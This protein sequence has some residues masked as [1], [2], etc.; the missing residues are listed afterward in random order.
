MLN[1]IVLMKFKPEVTDGEIAEL[2]EALD[3]LP[4]YITEIHS[5]EFG[6]DIVRSDRSYDFALVAMFAN[7]ETLQRYQEHPRHLKVLEKIRAISPD[8]RVLLASGYSDREQHNRL[9]TYDGV[10]FVGKPFVADEI[11]AKVRSTL[12]RKELAPTSRNQ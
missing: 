9:L 1:H 8:I 3:D 5:Y 10:E 4:N 2:E 6:R 7:L 11:L 12:D